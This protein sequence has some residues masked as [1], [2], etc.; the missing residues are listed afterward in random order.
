MRKTLLYLLIA[1]FYA[2]L[3]GSVT[4]A[5]SQEPTKSA[6]IDAIGCV[7]RGVEPGCMI[8]MSADGKPLYSF[9]EFKEAQPGEMLAIEGTLVDIDTCMQGR[10]VTIAKWSNLGWPCK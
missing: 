10:R 1:V 4:V 2:A 7:K 9:G 8:L 6:V 5:Y 3:R